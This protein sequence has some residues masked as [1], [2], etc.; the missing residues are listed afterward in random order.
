MCEC[1]LAFLYKCVCV[2]FRGLGNRFSSRRQYVWSLWHRGLIRRSWDTGPDR[3]TG[4]LS[5]SIDTC[6]PDFIRSGAAAHSLKLHVILLQP[7]DEK[8]SGKNRSCLCLIIIHI[9]DVESFRVV[10]TIKKVMITVQENWLVLFILFYF[11][12]HENLK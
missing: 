4:V 6:S 2:F 8:Y 12:L 9:V 3:Q 5:S 11:M 1:V 10:S 7:Q